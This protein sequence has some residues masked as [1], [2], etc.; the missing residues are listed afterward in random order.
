MKK[1]NYGIDAPKV[2]RNMIDIGILLFIIFILLSFGLFPQI[3][4]FKV[5]VISTAIC[6][7]IVSFLMIAYS[8]YGKFR[9]KDRIINLH[10]W[11]G[12]EKVLD[13]AQDWDY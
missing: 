3:A 9:H 2:I 1:V 6:L 4:S 7:L 8:R 11:K 13:I 12:N 10:Q 5:T